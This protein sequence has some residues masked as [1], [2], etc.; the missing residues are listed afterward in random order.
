MNKHLIL[1]IGVAM[2][3][4]LMGCSSE[5]STGDTFMGYEE[6]PTTLTGRWNMVRVDDADGST[7]IP[8][9]Q[10]VITFLDN[11]YAVVNNTIHKYFLSSG[12]YPYQADG[13]HITI[14]SGGI[15]GP[16]HYSYEFKE[17]GMLLFE[18]DSRI[19]F[20]K[21]KHVG[22]FDDINYD[23]LKYQFTNIDTLIIASYVFYDSNDNPFYLIRHVRS[24]PDSWYE[25]HGEI[26]GFYHTEGFEVKAV[27]W[28]GTYGGGCV[29]YTDMRLVNI[30]DRKQK[31]SENIPDYYW[32]QSKPGW[33]H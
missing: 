9:G 14:Q 4:T 16:Q 5:G 17:G 1:V 27:V 21:V 31:K 23:E 33:A 2:M 26:E 18:G 11:N 10:F 29:M 15:V 22:D 13:N 19:S 30:L 3:L 25:F 28:S 32:K 8:D 20:K 6:N 7:N 12:N 24:N